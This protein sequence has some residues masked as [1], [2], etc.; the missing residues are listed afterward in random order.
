MNRMTPQTTVL[1]A[2]TSYSDNFGNAIKYVWSTEL[3]I[4]KTVTRR[5]GKLKIKVLESGLKKTNSWK[6]EKVDVIEDYKKLL[7]H[8]EQKTFGIA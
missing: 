1:A 4:R 6:T 3:P 2:S 5:D 7:G 8:L